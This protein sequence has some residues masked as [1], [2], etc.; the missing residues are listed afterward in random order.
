MKTTTY[1]A[2]LCL[3]LPC[4][5]QAD[6]VPSDATAVSDLMTDA[7][8]DTILKKMPTDEAT[9]T[10][11]STPIETMAT[12]SLDTAY[13]SESDVS[14][15]SHHSWFDKHHTKTR[16]WLQRTAHK[17]DGW[18]GTSDDDQ[19]AKA[20]LRVMMDTNWNSQDGAVVSPRVRGRL[21]LPTLENKFSIVFGDDRL[22]VDTHS[23]VN[24][25]DRTIATPAP[26]ERL[27]DRQRVKDDNASLALRW[28]KFL[29]NNTI[30]TDVDLGV[31]TNDIFVKVQAQKKWQMPNQVQ[32]RLEQVYRYGIKSKHNAITTLEFARPMSPTHSLINKTQA[33]YTHKDEE[34]AG[35]ANSLYQ[36]HYH[37]SR[38]GTH[39]L[40]YGLYA[41]GDIAKSG[42]ILNTYGP[43]VSYRLPVWRNWFFVQTDVSYYN[44]RANDQKHRLGVFS[45]LEA[46]F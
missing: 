29:K 11:D 6:D 36:Q 35:W 33:Y 4:V 1:F 32:G 12:P 44:N 3:A 15:H 2:C 5:S 39:E 24:N 23:G 38:L 46:V 26:D 17:M 19:P 14:L 37:Q 34:Q 22:D 20:S 7:D 28:S 40:S 27:I 31:R 41:G 43:Y 30:E 9:A 13:A 45:R 42:T 10:A 25:D 18:F 16:Q 21:R 8:T